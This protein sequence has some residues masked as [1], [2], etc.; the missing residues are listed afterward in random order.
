[1]ACGRRDPDGARAPARACGRTVMG[2]LVRTLGTARAA[3]D[4]FQQ[5]LLEAWQRGA[6]YDPGRGPRSPG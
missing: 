1:M 4:V 5:V 6:A 2:F 3:E